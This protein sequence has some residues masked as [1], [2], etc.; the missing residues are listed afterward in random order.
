MKRTLLILSVWVLCPAAMVPA[1]EFQAPG[2]ALAVDFPSGWAAGRSDDPTVV[3][4]L[5]KGKSFFEFARLDS[6]LSDYY[7]KARVKEQV[8]S[9]RGKGNSL[10]GDIRQAG[11][12]GVSTV[13]YTSYESMGSQVYIGFFTY[14][15]LSYAI[16]ASGLGDGDLRCA[17]STI[18]KPGEKIE[19]PKTRK[20]KT[21]RKKQPEPEE[22]GVQIF[23]VDEPLP[24]LAGILAAAADPAAVKVEDSTPVLMRAAESARPSAGAQ[25]FKQTQDFLANLEFREDP[26]REP[27]IPR[28]PL[29][30][31]VWGALITL[32][33]GGAFWAKAAAAK[34][35]NP[36]LP[37]PPK[38]LPPDF[39]FPF[40]ISREV[41]SRDRTY[42]ALTRQKQLLQASFNSGHEIY[43]AGSVYAGV[44]FHVFWSLLAFAGN[45]D[46]VTGALLLLPGGRLWASAPELFFAVPFIAGLRMYFS[47]K[48]VLRL[49]DSQSNLLMSARKDVSYCLIRDGKGKEIAR[50]IKKGGLAARTWDFVDTDNRVVFTIRDDYPSTRILRKIFGRLDGSLR[51]RYGIFAAERRAGFL[52]LDP[53]SADR[54]QLHLDFDFA[55][56]AHPAQ[57]LV[58]VLYLI[59]KENDPVYPSPF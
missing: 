13:Y 37:L 12:R 34:L 45:G 25:A 26:S 27:F 21:V 51:S 50:L 4:K 6:E 46:S 2:A 32:W 16:S 28:R 23:K 19:I 55:R 15:G 43:L 53:T 1:R 35:Q 33:A 18:R 24:T 49:Y 11:I 7:L 10:S 56:L 29:S 39:F 58:S 5:E 3:L 54:F 36:K 31:Y 44:V 42:N 57:I 9:L 48:Q 38:G 40:L 20:I 8:D 47:R 59:S 22:G 17:V 14:K 52:F 30:F 41:T